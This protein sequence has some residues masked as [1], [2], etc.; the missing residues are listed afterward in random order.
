MGDNGIYNNHTPLPSK[1]LNIQSCPQSHKTFILESQESM[2][3]DGKD[4]LL[5]LTDLNSCR[6]GF[7]R[8][9][10]VCGL[11]LSP[12]A[13]TEDGQEGLSVD[14]P[15]HCKTPLNIPSNWGRRLC[16]DYCGSCI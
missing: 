3:A 7:C 11:G 1:N 8:A 9:S 13:L 16:L 10:G 4:L 14:G 12:R 6:S 15:I 5:I 2:V